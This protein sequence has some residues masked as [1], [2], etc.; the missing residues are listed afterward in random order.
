MA[1]GCSDGGIQCCRLFLCGLIYVELTQCFPLLIGV[2]LL[3]FTIFF[4]E[5]IF[6]MCGRI[7]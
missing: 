7:S 6:I 3:G 2:V 4:N 5:L 1:T